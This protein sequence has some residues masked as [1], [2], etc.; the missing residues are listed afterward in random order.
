MIVI[1]VPFSNS[2]FFNKYFIRSWEA[3]KWLLDIIGP[4]DLNQDNELLYNNEWKWAFDIGMQGEY[5][6]FRHPTDAILFK[7]TWI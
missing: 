5:Y 3:T 2:E 7:M 1:F 6:Y 4:G